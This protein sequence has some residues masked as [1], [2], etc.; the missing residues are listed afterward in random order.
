MAA[1]AFAADYKAKVGTSPSWVAGGAYDVARLQT[2]A[3]EVPSEELA[4]RTTRLKEKPSK[5]EEEAKRLKA[6]E[7]ERLTAPD[8]QISFTDPDS[9]S[10]AT[11]GRCSGMVGYNVQAAV[12]RRTI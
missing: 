7:K 1:E 6:I 5:L 4:A 8:Q 3:G 12:D 11:S 9:R 2:A 10:M